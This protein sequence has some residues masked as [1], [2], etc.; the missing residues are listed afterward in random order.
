MLGVGLWGRQRCGGRTEYLRDRIHLELELEKVVEKGVP[1]QVQVLVD[2]FTKLEWQR[3]AT[4]NDGSDGEQ[5]VLMDP[6]IPNE[7]VPAFAHLSK[8]SQHPLFTNKPLRS[9]T[10][11]Y[12]SITHVNSVSVSVYHVTICQQTPF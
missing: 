8:T 2:A 11:C 5:E 3:W 9:H 12:V 10:S 1:L 6:D 4:K 7:L